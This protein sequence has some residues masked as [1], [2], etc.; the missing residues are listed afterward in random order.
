MDAT[1]DV[2]KFMAKVSARMVV[3]AFVDLGQLK[4]LVILGIVAFN[5]LCGLVDLLAGARNDDIFVE[6]LA[7]GMA[8]T[9]KLHPL[10]LGEL[11]IVLRRIG[12]GND[13][14]ALEHAIRQGFEVTA[15][16]HEYT[17]FGSDADLNHLKVV[18]EIAA[19]LDKLMLNL[20][21][22]RVVGRDGL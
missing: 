22:S 19:E 4:P 17:W 9:R 11:Q 5:S 20:T 14:A 16:D 2:Y 10:L 18:R 12:L 15:T 1:E 8:V 3:A 13:L 21:S 7:D 6:N